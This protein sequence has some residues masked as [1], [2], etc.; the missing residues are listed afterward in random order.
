MTD[1]PKG[2]DRAV[3]AVGYLAEQGD[4]QLIEGDRDLLR[5]EVRHQIGWAGGVYV[6]S[7]GEW[8]YAERAVSSD[9]SNGETERVSL[10]LT[11]CF[12]GFWAAATEGTALTTM[13]E[14]VEWHGAPVR[15]AYHGGG[16]AFLRFATTYWTMNVVW[17]AL[18]SSNHVVTG[19]LRR[20]STYLGDIFFPADLSGVP[21]L[22]LP[23]IDSK[24]WANDQHRL[25]LA[26]ASGI[27]PQK[28]IQGNPL[29]PEKG[30]KSNRSRI[31]RWFS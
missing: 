26:F 18:I 22:G 7:G 4:L 24:Q 29:L 23:G 5:S 13:E 28:F 11:A 8:R 6:A 16:E 12:H 20:L 15:E 30:R 31:S 10:I 1:T 17:R 21:A 9:L 3:L 19:V 27:D 14:V 2:L 25:L